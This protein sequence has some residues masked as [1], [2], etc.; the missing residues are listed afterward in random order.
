[1]PRAG[2]G[3][4]GEPSSSTVGDQAGSAIG[5][6][7]FGSPRVPCQRTHF[8]VCRG[9]SWPFLL[10]PGGSR[11]FLAWPGGSRVVLVWPGRGRTFWLCRGGVVL[12]FAWLGGVVVPCA[13]VVRDRSGVPVVTAETDC[14]GAGGDEVLVA[15]PVGVG[16]VAA[17][18]G[19]LAPAP[20]SSDVVLTMVL[21]TGAVSEA[22]PGCNATGVTA[23]TPVT[24]TA[25][26]AAVTAVVCA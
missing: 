9:G 3:V 5:P 20:E 11:L 8:L 25:P 24:A 23:V 15:V 19:D 13:G 26:I 10:W 4:R 16:R 2:T 7:A 6:F 12:P 14:C 21:V 18:A 22:W 17:A 1:M